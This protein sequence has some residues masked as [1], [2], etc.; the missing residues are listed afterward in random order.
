MNLTISI[1]QPSRQAQSGS[2]RT[3]KKGGPDLS[4]KM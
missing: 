4:S 2:K 3:S 1:T